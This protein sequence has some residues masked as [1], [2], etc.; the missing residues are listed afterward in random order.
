MVEHTILRVTLRPAP[1]P[2]MRKRKIESRGKLSARQLRTA[3]LLMEGRSDREIA[4]ARKTAGG[5]DSAHDGRSEI[6]LNART[7][8]ASTCCEIAH[9]LINS[10]RRGILVSDLKGSIVKANDVF[11]RGLGYAAED[12]PGKD[13][14]EIRAGEHLD[15]AKRLLAGE[16]EV[17]NNGL[18]RAADG[19]TLWARE[20]ST[21]G[22][23][24]RGNPRY[25]VTQIDCFGA[26]DRD[27]LE[28]LSR[29]EHQVL[30]FVVSG[31]TSKEIGSRLGISASSVDTYRRRLMLKLRVADLAQLI[32]FAIRHG[33]ATA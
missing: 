10:T 14:A 30:G 15:C 9:A 8:E 13:L 32:R 11:A 31:R 19:N 5:A 6:R 33:I 4:A 3:Q 2:S 1:M 25:V 26:D 23:N 20:R 28:I 24:R 27:P 21:L 17:V 16:R 22:R 12:L 29:R 18:Y 7:A